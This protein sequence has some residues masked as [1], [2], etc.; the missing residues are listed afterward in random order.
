MIQINGEAVQE[1]QKKLSTSSGGTD[2]NIP[3]SL[4]ETVF[5]GEDDKDENN[6]LD[7]IAQLDMEMDQEDGPDWMFDAGETS[8]KDL[9]YTFCPAPHQKQALHL[10]TQ[11]FRAHPFFSLR[12]GSTRSALEI[13]CKS[14]FQMYQF[15]KKQGLCEVW[16]YMWN[17]WYC[18]TMW[19][20]WAW[21]SS[22]YLT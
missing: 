17:C 16:A 14:V 4:G 7:D 8:S 18:Q 1:Y 10:F 9:N 20:L 12:D 5:T 13:Q 3:S 2:G 6:I 19:P 22:P 11:H 21:S 15:C